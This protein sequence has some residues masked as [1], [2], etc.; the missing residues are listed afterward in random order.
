MNQQPIILL[1]RYEI[2]KRIFSYS[3][4]FVFIA[5]D[6][7]TNEQVIIKQIPFTY[8][9]HYLLYKEVLFTNELSLK[10]LKILNIFWKKGSTDLYI[11]YENMET[12]LHLAIKTEIFEEEK[13]RQYIL[14]QL[15]LILQYL[16]SKSVIF[17][18]LTTYNI[19]L[20][21]DCLIKIGNFET[22]FLFI[23]SITE[24]EIKRELQ[25]IDKNNTQQWYQSPEILLNSKI[26]SYST[27]IW[28]FGCI[29]Y[30]LYLG[31]PLFSSASLFNQLE[32][33][34]EITGYPSE[35]DISYF[36]DSN[37][38]YYLKFI[39]PKQKK[40]LKDLKLNENLIDL[41]EKIFI[42]NPTKRISCFEL[43]DHLY[44]KD[45]QILKQFYH[46]NKL[47]YHSTV[48]ESE[49]FQM[50]EKFESDFWEKRKTLFKFHIIKKLNPD[51][52]F[53]YK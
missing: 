18:N 3:N 15:L 2:K 33:I 19:L 5:K 28:S 47:F 45:F 51:I 49:L 11:V 12:T 22:S 24:N 9:R 36:K 53:R 25:E 37:L 27:D 39:L 16:Y 48:I 52:Y 30:E 8:K 46:H 14:Y 32:K 6:K 34:F 10:T 50:I 40:S 21:S 38:N 41:L 7:Q 1:D 44:L 26:L 17:I 31:K 42:F 20:N 23:D 4:S 43:L 29:I 13:Q 35:D